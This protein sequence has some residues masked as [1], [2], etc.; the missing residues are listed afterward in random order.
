MYSNYKFQNVY[1]SRNHGTMGCEQSL[2]VGH[3]HFG[4]QHCL[5]MGD[6]PKIYH[7]TGRKYRNTLQ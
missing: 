5:K 1:E 2:P 7:L 6:I 3:C 4:T